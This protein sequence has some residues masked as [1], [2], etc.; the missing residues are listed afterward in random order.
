MLEIE[1][2][3]GPASTQAIAD[4]HHSVTNHSDGVTRC[5]IKVAHQRLVARASVDHVLIRKAALKGVLQ[6][7]V[8]PR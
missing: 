8:A 4:V 5:A 7:K 3:I 2:D 1:L 6:V